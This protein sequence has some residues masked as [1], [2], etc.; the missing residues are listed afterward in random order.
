MFFVVRKK[1]GINYLCIVRNGLGKNLYLCIFK[2]E[3]NKI[4]VWWFFLGNYN[5]LIFII[6]NYENWGNILDFEV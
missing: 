4:L 3:L 6:M 5:I 1:F 2:N